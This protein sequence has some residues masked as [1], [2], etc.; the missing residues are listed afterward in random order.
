[1]PQVLEKATHIAEGVTSLIAGSYVLSLALT[2]DNLLV[3]VAFGVAG[4]YLILR[5]GTKLRAANF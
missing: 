5:S 4:A 3:K 1:M 2:K